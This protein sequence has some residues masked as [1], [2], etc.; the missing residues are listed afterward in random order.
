MD[1]SS[2]LQQVLPA[3]LP[4]RARVIHITARHLSL[5]AAANEH[6]NLTRITAP[7]EAVIKHVLDSLAPWQ[8]FAHAATVLDAGTG[9]GFPGIPLAAALPDTRFVLADSTQKKARFVEN[10]V[11]TLDLPNVDV[12]AERAEDILRLTRFH[13]VTA[14]A[15][16]PLER[17]LTYFAQGLKTGATALLYKGPDAETEIADARTEA[18]RRNVRMDLLMRYS[19]PDGLGA[20]AIVRICAAPSKTGQ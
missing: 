20:R 5:I 4:N 7:R 6:M 3:D 17:A 10:A 16:A 15:V 8:H 13:I 14:R 1:F 12:S 19:L 18:L 11:A 2:E 9:A